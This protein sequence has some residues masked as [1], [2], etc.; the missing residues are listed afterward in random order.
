MGINDRLNRLERLVPEEREDT[1]MY[2]ISPESQEL[3]PW[4]S[5]AIE[6]YLVGRGMSIVTWQGEPDSLSAE[7]AGRGTYRVTPDGCQPLEED[8]QL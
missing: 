3:P 7:I 8:R 1:V 5:P 6:P 2:I 4:A